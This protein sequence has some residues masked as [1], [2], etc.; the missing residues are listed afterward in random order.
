MSNHVLF[1]LFPPNSRPKY[2]C[3]HGLD[4]VLIYHVDEDEMWLSCGA[5]DCQPS[6]DF[7]RRVE[8]IAFDTEERLSDFGQ[9]LKESGLGHLVYETN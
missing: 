3:S 4:P 5:A 1:V 6:L 8:V 2:K 9:R 7:L